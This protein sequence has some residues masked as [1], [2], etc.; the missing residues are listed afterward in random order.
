MVP[1]GS[2]YNKRKNTITGVLPVIVPCVSDKCVSFNLCRLP[3][4]SGFR[5]QYFSVLATFSHSSSVYLK[6]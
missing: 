1:S 5:Y 6:V 3:A 4:G 2:F